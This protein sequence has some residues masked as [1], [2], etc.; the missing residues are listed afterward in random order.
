MKRFA[1]FLWLSMVL[2]VVDA[3][4]ETRTLTFTNFN[5]VSIE[6]GIRFSISRGDAYHIT[7][8]G[9]PN[10]L[11]R[12]E[13]KQNGTRLEFS[14][15]SAAR[16]GPIN[17]D[18]TLPAL[19]RLDLSGGSEGKMTMPTGAPSFKG[20][21]SGGAAL[22]GQINSR[23][24][25]L[26]SSGGSTVTLSGTA[27]ALRLTGTGAGQFELKNLPAAGARITLSG[28]STATVTVNGKIDATLDG[29]SELTY[30]GNA[31][32]GTQNTSGGS[33]IRKGP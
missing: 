14:I 15:R 22:T 12:L 27:E 17:L 24:I 19:R 28:G 29:G 9:A 7:A 30:Y 18:I 25:D 2:V 33:E 11:K 16:T 21:F 32:L 8:T 3:A 5:E 10:D 31:T 6:S 1:L 13:V 4:A 23:D 20:E 26:N